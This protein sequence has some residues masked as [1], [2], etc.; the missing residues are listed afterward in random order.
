MCTFSLCLQSKTNPQ[1]TWNYLTLS[2]IALRL[3]ETKAYCFCTGFNFL[4][5]M[6]IR[7]HLYSSLNA[8][9]C[10][11]NK[12]KN[13]EIKYNICSKTCYRK[14]LFYCRHKSCPNPIILLKVGA[15]ISV[16]YQ[17]TLNTDMKEA[18][19]S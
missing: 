18:F 15:G 1:Q 2:L 7:L 13:R 16:I 5:C 17:S 12:T 19:P 8:S 9:I 3:K 10:T 11:R 6:Q 14:L 4:H